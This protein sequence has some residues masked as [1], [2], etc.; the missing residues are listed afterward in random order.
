MATK[1]P[2]PAAV[3]QSIL[4]MINIF[5]CCSPSTLLVPQV[6][7]ESIFDSQCMTS[8][9]SPPI[10]VSQDKADSIPPLLNVSQA[11]AYDEYDD[12]I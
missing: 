2:V 5:F 1:L 4:L 10:N 6:K 12:F 7:L 3:V 9:I 8:M 11:T